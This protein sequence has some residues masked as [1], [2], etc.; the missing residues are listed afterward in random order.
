MSDYIYFEAELAVH[1]FLLG[2]IL[3]VS[4]D[5]LR[6]FRLLIPHH[7][8]AVGAEDFLYWLYCA[9][10]TFLLLFYANSGELRGY[11][12]A[13]VFL[14]MIL[15]DRLVSK[16]VFHFLKKGKLWFTIKA[17]RF[18]IKARKHEP[19][20]KKTKGHISKEEG[21]DS[22]GTRPESADETKIEI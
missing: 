15:Y 7:V 17:G 13:G 20:R 10:L 12:I 8:L 6:L 3:M 2:I 22:H 18:T 21:E 19:C 1:S 14:G 16:N 11:V 4:Y 5:L 9:V